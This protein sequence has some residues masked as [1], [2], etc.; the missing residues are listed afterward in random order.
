M[1]VI[2]RM[3]ALSGEGS[4]ARPSVPVAAL[5]SRTRFLAARHPR[6]S[7]LSAYSRLEASSELRVRDR[8][9][10]AGSGSDRAEKGRRGS[11]AGGCTSTAREVE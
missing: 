11:E 4:S 1:S 5:A 6:P 7:P 10:L 3:R 8:I 2:Q 9:V